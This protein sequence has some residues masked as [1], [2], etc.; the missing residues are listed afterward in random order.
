LI[1]SPAL[2]PTPWDDRFE[3]FAKALAVKLANFL[4]H[5]AAAPHM[6]ALHERIRERSA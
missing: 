2:P 1:A 4:P 5:L 6:V 3:T